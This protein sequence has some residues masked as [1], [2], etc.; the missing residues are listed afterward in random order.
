[1]SKRSTLSE[2]AVLLEKAEEL[3]PVGTSWRHYRDNAGE[4]P[5]TITGHAINEH[6]ESVAVLYTSDAKVI[7]S[8]PIAEF[9]ETLRGGTQQ[10]FQKII[11]EDL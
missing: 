2:L 8:R 1:M 4:R 11:I 7:F 3:V 10:R 6:D 9:L 5:Y